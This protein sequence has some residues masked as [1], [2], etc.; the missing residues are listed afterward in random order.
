[1]GKGWR[2]V[3]TFLPGEGWVLSILRG[4]ALGPQ[5]ENNLPFLPAFRSAKDSD[6]FEGGKKKE[7]GKERER[8]TSLIIGLKALLRFSFKGFV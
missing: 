3:I 6:S 2:H 5:V 4:H 8:E 1:M 7:K